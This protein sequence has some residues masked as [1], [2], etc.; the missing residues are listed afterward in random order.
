MKHV[1][2]GVP[3]PLSAGGTT[4]GRAAFQARARARAPRT[5]PGAEVATGAAPP[6]RW[7]PRALG[8]GREG[9]S[10]TYPRDRPCRVSSSRAS[11]RASRSTRR[12]RGALRRSIGGI[13]RHV[14]PERTA[15]LVRRVRRRRVRVRARRRRAASQRRADRS[16]SKRRRAV[17]VRRDRRGRVPRQARAG[18]SPGRDG[19]RRRGEHRDV[20]AVRGGKGGRGRA[21]VRAG[22]HPADV[23][24]TRKRSSATSVFPPDETSTPPSTRAEEKKKP[25][26]VRH[27]PRRVLDAKDAA[28]ALRRDEFQNHVGDSTREA[29]VA[30]NAGVSDGEKEATFTFYPRAAGWSS[31]AP[32]DAETREN[33]RRFVERRLSLPSSTETLDEL[34][35][36]PRRPRRCTRWR[37]SARGCWRA[38]GRLRRRGRGR[39]R[40]VG[41]E[42]RRSVP[43]GAR[44]RISDG[45][46]RFARGLARLAFSLAVSAVTA[47][48]LGGK[49]T[50]A[51]PLVTVSDVIRANGLGGFA[52]DRRDWTQPGKAVRGR[53]RSTPRSASSRVAT[54]GSTERTAGRSRR[55]RW[56]CT[57]TSATVCKP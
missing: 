3:G 48:L 37:R 42:T 12:R 6:P 30:Y 32:D 57:T 55:S 31:L 45:L 15:A 44:R 8:T 11:R 24:G 33:V 54:P 9:R 39:R 52:R 29:V 28:L 56:R 22:T 7:A 53:F 36:P 47:Y 14:L 25:V 43:E 10:E 18:D 34:S 1:A 5:M 41:R 21:R 50:S 40:R 49:T 16:V 46:V 20:R 38:D 2:R 51:C 17:S 27:A 13:P 23:R 19:H 26:S 4:T 35:A